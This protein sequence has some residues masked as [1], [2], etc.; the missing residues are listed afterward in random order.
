MV[1]GKEGFHKGGY[2]TPS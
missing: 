2:W 1:P